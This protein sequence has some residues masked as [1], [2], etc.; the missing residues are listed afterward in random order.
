MAEL[1]DTAGSSIATRLV[2]TWRW[3]AKFTG[4]LLIVTAPLCVKY[5]I[6]RPV[7]AWTTTSG[8]PNFTGSPTLE[9]T[10]CC[11]FGSNSKSRKATEP[12]AALEPPTG[13]PG[14]P[15]TLLPVV[16]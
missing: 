14:S 1:S 8:V 15:A 6:A 7:S 5:L 9:K 10:N 13:Y 4:G 16:V 11:F 2:R 12:C 3:K